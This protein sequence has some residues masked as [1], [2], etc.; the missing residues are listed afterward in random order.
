MTTN[1]TKQEALEAFNRLDA[2]EGLSSRYYGCGYEHGFKPAHSCP[3]DGCEISQ[4]QNDFNTIRDYIN[5]VDDAPKRYIVKDLS[6]EDKDLIL[7]SE[8][9]GIIEVYKQDQWQ[10]IETAPKDG[11]YILCIVN[12]SR[13]SIV[14]WGC[15]FDKGMFGCDP[16]TFMSE[17]EFEDYWNNVSYEPTHWM[18]LPTPPEPKES[19]E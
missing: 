17:E 6:D 11:T 8:K 15:Y 18:P 14:H 16:E 2:S 1:P 5:G 9:S 7:N 3:T 4:A 13:P 19:E 10:P 12:N